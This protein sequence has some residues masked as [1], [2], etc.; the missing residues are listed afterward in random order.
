MGDAWPRRIPGNPKK[1]Q[2]K[3][4][5]PCNNSAGTTFQT[6]LKTRIE[7]LNAARMHRLSQL[8]PGM[9]PTKM[10]AKNRYWKTGTRQLL[11]I[12]DGDVCTLK[13]N[14]GR[15]PWRGQLRFSQKTQCCAYP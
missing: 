1:Q 6:D 12:P 13:H 2:Q 8:D 10:H 9:P 11:Q 5:S 14:I 15:N 4:G 7:A 3:N